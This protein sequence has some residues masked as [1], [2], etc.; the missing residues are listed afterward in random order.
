MVPAWV[1]LRRQPWGLVQAL[2]IMST[3]RMK[4][5]KTTEATATATSQTVA[6]SLRAGTKVEMMTATPVEVIPTM[7]TPDTTTM[8]I[9]LPVVIQ[10][11]MILGTTPAQT[12]TMIKPMRRTTK[13]GADSMVRTPGVSTKTTLATDNLEESPRMQMIVVVIADVTVADVGNRAATVA[14]TVDGSSP[15]F[16]AGLETTTAVATIV[17]VEVAA[18]MMNRIG[19]KRIKLDLKQLRVTLQ[20]LLNRSGMEELARNPKKKISY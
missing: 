4:G 6:F 2:V 8:G 13:T 16:V 3:R 20:R 19:R 11:D 1:W 12:R 10:S 17:D 18:V 15:S 9:I 14:M 5:T 7:D